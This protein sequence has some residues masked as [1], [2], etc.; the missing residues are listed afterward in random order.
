MD[1]KT[2]QAC[3]RIIEHW[4]ETAADRAEYR[5]WRNE[6]GEGGGAEGSGGGEAEG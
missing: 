3:N 4:T 6:K 5:N 1:S 2:K